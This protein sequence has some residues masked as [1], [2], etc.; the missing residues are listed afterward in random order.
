MDM[1][2]KFKQAMEEFVTGRINDWGL[3]PTEA[4]TE[5]VNQAQEREEKLRESFSEEQNKLWNEYELACS[6]RTGEEFDFYYRAG[7]GDALRFLYLMRDEQ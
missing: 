5:A 6:L 2:E 4:V 1:E 7:F 3:F